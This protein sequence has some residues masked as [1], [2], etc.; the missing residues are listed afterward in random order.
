MT[1]EPR[2]F[3][4]TVTE[5][6]TRERPPPLLQV[7]PT[8]Y[9][10]LVIVNSHWPRKS[11]WPLV[12]TRHPLATIDDNDDNNNNDEGFAT[13]SSIEHDKVKIKEEERFL[14]WPEEQEEQVFK[15]GDKEDNVSV[16]EEDELNGENA[17]PK[18]E[19]ISVTPGFDDAGAGALSASEVHVKKERVALPDL[20]KGRIDHEQSMNFAIL[21]SAIDTNANQGAVQNNNNLQLTA[22]AVRVA[23]D[24]DTCIP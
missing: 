10:L 17:T 5:K 9:P 20:S 11:L 7:T 4:K 21:S 2:G 14:F 24:E 16:K 22:H 3:R 19:H 12:A 6:R 15:E 1:Q 18:K 23:R 8:R 13:T